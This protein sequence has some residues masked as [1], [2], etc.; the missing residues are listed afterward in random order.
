M[1]G[2]SFLPPLFC[3]AMISFPCEQFLAAQIG[4]IIL[5]YNASV[6]LVCVFHSMC[7]LNILPP[8][9][10][11]QKAT[12]SPKTPKTPTLGKKGKENTATPSKVLAITP[13]LLKCSY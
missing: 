3:Y 2:N 4:I 6:V 1:Q 5:R 11:L 12:K 10:P 8:T 13:H 7:C 9:I